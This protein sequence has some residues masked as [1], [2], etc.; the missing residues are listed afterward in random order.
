VC[1][2]SNPLFEHDG[3]S[4][5]CRPHMDATLRRDVSSAL[6]VACYQVIPCTRVSSPVNRQEYGLR[7]QLAPAKTRS[8]HA[9]PQP[10]LSS[11]LQ[12]KS[13]RRG[14]VKLL[15]ATCWPTHSQRP[16][17]KEKAATCSCQGRAR[18]T[19]GTWLAAGPRGKLVH[20]AV[21]DDV[22]I[23]IKHNLLWCMVYGLGLLSGLKNVQP[24]DVGGSQVES[25]RRGR[26]PARQTRG[27]D[28]GNN[29]DRANIGDGSLQTTARGRDFDRIQISIWQE[30]WPAK[31]TSALPWTAATER[32]V[33]LG[34]NVS[35]CEKK[36]G[37]CSD[38]WLEP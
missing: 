20:A 16:G 29:V 34:E 27:L 38:P 13:V 15:H 25:Q 17:A 8:A 35:S 30:R 9:T 2:R 18:A 3:P 6:L 31:S 5:K 28:S 21:P 24:D 32:L 7:W 23:I 26:A 11:R 4:R 10:A 22:I 19:N 36:A 37:L 1:A 14:G 12:S 33:F